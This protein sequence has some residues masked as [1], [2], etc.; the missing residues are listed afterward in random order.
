MK[1]EQV[2]F[3]T[4]FRILIGNKNLKGAVMVLAAG[5]IEGCPTQA[6]PSRPMADRDRG[7][8]RRHHQWPEPVAQGGTDSQTN[9]N[10]AVSSEYWWSPQF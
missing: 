8:R 4:G 9:A 10:V 5:V 3:R 7:H 6:R 1:H 2:N